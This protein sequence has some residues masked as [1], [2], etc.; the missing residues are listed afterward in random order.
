MV[1]SIESETH[2]LT[3]I[4][5]TFSKDVKEETVISEYY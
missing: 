5:M 2:C 1:D 4:V 3:E